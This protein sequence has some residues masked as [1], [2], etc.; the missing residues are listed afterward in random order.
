MG[1]YKYKIKETSTTGGGIGA[2][3]FTPGTGAQY[4]TP[5]AFSKKGKYSD[6]GMYT[7]K[8]GYKLVPNKIKNSGVEV[9]QLF[10][11]A[12]SSNEFQQERINAFDIIEKE[13]NSIYIMLSNSKNETVQYYNDNPSSYSVI[14]PTDLILDYIKDIKNLLTNP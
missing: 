3:S 2:A 5:K 1:K 10:N 14:I 13:I 12:Q 8:F 6:G 11:E 7:K 4:A 9:K